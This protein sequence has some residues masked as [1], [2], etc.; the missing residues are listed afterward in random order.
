MR[1]VHAS[2]YL[3]TTHELN[4]LPYYPTFSSLL[5]TFST[6]STPPTSLIQRLLTLLASTRNRQPVYDQ[7][8][9]AT[10]HESICKARSTSLQTSHSDLHGTSEQALF[11]LPLD[12]AGPRS[13]IVSSPVPSRG[14]VRG[15][16]ELERGEGGG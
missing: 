6:Q 8:S 11:F 10:A 5:L 4:D 16:T 15:W 14:V 7:V 1:L 3:R 13:H 2:K 12:T 9:P